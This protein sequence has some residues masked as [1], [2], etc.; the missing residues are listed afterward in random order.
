MPASAG[1]K[2][3]QCMAA[4]YHPV[5]LLLLDRRGAFRKDDRVRLQLDLVVSCWCF[6]FRGS[7][8][9]QKRERIRGCWWQGSL[10]REWNSI[11]EA[12]R[13]GHMLACTST[14]YKGRDWPWANRMPLYSQLHGS[15]PWRAKVANKPFLLWLH[16][17]CIIS[18][19]ALLLPVLDDA[20][21]S[22]RIWQLVASTS[23]TGLGA[24]IISASS[25]SVP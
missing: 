15:K 21:L 25:N 18:G 2:M 19:R 17:I 14:T 6:I 11:L 13:L 5:Q 16:L 1:N 12:G 22:S 3:M 24:R 9:F 8:G 4:H 20:S 23:S 7:V 10:Q